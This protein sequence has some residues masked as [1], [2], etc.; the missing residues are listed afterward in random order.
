MLRRL[1]TAPLA[2]V[3]VSVMSLAA[4]QECS[5]ETEPND[6]PPQAT[7]MTGAGPDAAGRMPAGRAHTACF[8]GDLTR[9]DDQ[10]M[11]VW[12]VGELESQQRW[13]IDLE[14]FAGHLTAVRLFSLEFTSDGGGVTS[15]QEIFYTETRDGS[16]TTSA[17]FLVAPGTYYLGVA[18]SAGEGAYVGHLRSVEQLGR[19]A[20]AQRPGQQ[21]R[22]AF[23]VFGPVE[24]E[25][26]Q[27]FA[28][29]E[30]NAGFVWNLELRAAAGTQVTMSLSGPEGELLA[31]KT[32]PDSVARQAGL[33]FTS[34]VYTLKLNGSTGM[35]WL[36]LE[37]LGRRSEGIEVEPNDN[38][39]NATLFPPASEMRGAGDGN[40]YY[41]VQVDAAA[42]AQAW[43]L[44]LQAS[45]NLRIRLY[46]AAG[47]EL[48][49]RT[50]S[51]GVLSALQ[52]SR[53][54]YRLLVSA[55]TGS[56][57]TLALTA[58]AP[59]T[60]G[61][62][63]E[64][65]DT[66][67]S[68]TPLGEES[69]ARG[70]LTQQDRDVFSLTV[71]GEPQLYRVQAVGP[72]VAGLEMLDASGRS[73]GIRARGEGR[74]RLDDL[75]LLPGTH[76]FELRGG[77][78]AY[79]LRAMSLG[80]APPPPSV[81]EMPPP[82][83]PLQPAQASQEEPAAPGGDPLTILPPPAGPPP[84]PG[85]SELEPN[86]DVSRASRLRPGEVHVG[87]LSS[88]T[89]LDF[90]RFHLAAEEYV[91]LELIP[92]TGSDDLALNLIG[93][94]TF[95]S[96]D[97]LDG[98]V[99]VERRLLAGDHS[100]RVSAPSATD[101][102]GYYQVRLTQL[103]TLAAPIDAEPNDDRPDASPLPAELAWDGVVGDSDT[104]DVYRL[105]VFATTTQ[106]R[107]RLATPGLSLAVLS[108]TGYHA[109]TNEGDEMVA[110]LPA[111]ERSWLHIRGRGRYSV[112]VSFDAEPDPAALR[113]SFSA[114]RLAVR[115][116]EQAIPVAAFWYEGQV[117]EAVATV[118]NLGDQPLAVN[119]SAAITN[120]RTSVEAPTV[121]ELAAGESRT[122]PV[123]VDLPSDLRD[124]LAPR[125]ELVATAAGEAAVAHVQLA[126]LCEAP[127]VSAYSYWPMP[128]SLLGRINL[129]SAGFGAT[130]HGESRYPNRDRQLIDGLA[131]PSAG[132]YLAPDSSATF[133]IAGGA[134]VR[135]VGTLLHPL[136]DQQTSRQLKGFVIETSL[137]GSSYSP[138]L[139]A[140]LSSTRVEQAFEFPEPVLARYARLVFVSSQ[141]GG[142][143]AYLGEWKLLAEDLAPF[144]E[145]NLAQPELG[146]HVV[147][148]EPLL[149]DYGNHVIGGAVE[150]RRPLDLRDAPGLSF[151]VGFHHGRAAQV[152]RIEWHDSGSED[153]GS[154][155][156][157]EQVTVEVSLAGPIG[158]W[159]PV[160]EWRLERNAEGVAVLNFDAPTWVRYL[161]LTMPKHSEDRY[162]WPPGRIG[163]IERQ[164]SDG[165]L[166]I[167][168][169]WGHYSREATYE[170]LV[171]HGGIGPTGTSVDAGDTPQTATQLASGAAAQGTVEVAVDADWYRVTLPEG[172]NHVRVRLVGDPTI[173][174]T[175]SLLDE[176]G[177]AVAYEVT[178]EDDGVTLDFFGE[179]GHYLL[180][181]EEPKRTV[182]FAWDTS[183]SVSRF[184]EIIYS[185]IA[186]FALGVD[187]EREAVQ[188]L[189]FNEPSPRWLLP[190]WSTVPERVQRAITDFD[191]NADSSN[192]YLHLLAAGNALRGR[193][194]TKALLFI[195]DAETGGYDL[196]PA[197]WRAL[198]E[199][200]TR[201]FTFEVSSSS[202][203]LP[204]DLM[205]DWAAANSGAYLAAASVGDVD[206]GFARVTCA[207]RR[208]KGYGVEVQTAFVAPPGP[209]SVSVLSV[210]DAHEGAVAVIFDASGS[211]GRAL[212]S[213]EPRIVAARRA[214]V[215]LIADTLPDDAN[216]TLRAFGHVAP[217]SCDTRLDVPLGPL[218]RQAA[219]AAVEGIEP[220]LLS[221]TPLADALAAVA[222]DLAGATGGRTVILITD[223]VESCGGDPAAAVTELR[224]AGPV[225]L[226]IVSLG[227][228]PEAHAEFEALAEAVGASYVDVTSFEGLAASIAA[229]LNP[230]VEFE[231]VDAA[232]AVVAR[233]VVDGEPVEVAMGLYSVR[234]LAAQ[235]VMFEDVRVPGERNVTVRLGTQ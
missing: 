80:P 198:E 207:L 191:R 120:V 59:P 219:L 56:T 83:E 37:K 23:S 114:G 168:G 81:E 167:L 194:G 45:D 216:F 177:A 77:E 17:E 52:L 16:P 4:A 55:P 163:V 100:L 61:F 98:S 73:M 166:S 110:T 108:E 21:L 222:G 32:G 153:L 63:V 5:Y 135:L 82:G 88:P 187:G 210:G 227:L 119:L 115:F 89:D 18:K 24:G 225:D 230:E 44:A 171:S 214:L 127:A 14:S 7:R 169:E 91:R 208:P 197:T 170:L 235:V 184:H 47:V 212:P 131:T 234:V 172:E 25:L 71:T 137:D 233:G 144:G 159:R 6:T 97:A 29:D 87:R 201:V 195:T 178:D 138:V 193:P 126:P 40:D 92:A 217:S 105:P 121:V 226:A 155:G 94:G 134:P 147:R 67:A 202:N 173:A 49:S 203:A 209:G 34:G 157:F 103:G 125:L 192:A 122:V 96:V 104:V 85:W 143:A 146:G 12:E 151:V 27:E 51:S 66:A 102:R 156:R 113:P 130:S 69:Q 185:T 190:L 140:E 53:G 124:D 74:L 176:A 64:P 2:A 215:A 175:Y 101:P 50:G 200:N 112:E 132:G 28:V 15:S 72:G 26:V 221:Q 160:A 189:A 43:D 150:A 79:A 20:S 35:T 90:Y 152:S 148:S 33:G 39:E 10:D 75:F 129:L 31:L 60:Q 205:Q 58:A 183:G 116:S 229:A 9:Q 165:Y 141:G 65:N 224:T 182:I 62:E 186:S 196:L 123:R 199:S 161:R 142:E 3:L 111:G 36:Q 164:A 206:A 22:G 117:V 154:G 128:S 86:D 118:E 38:W 139:T 181:L 19:W 11:F 162:F 42:A 13:V 57:Y 41:R 107:V 218:D 231:V 149:A 93:V 1:V 46:T 220:K 232:G 76:Y 180:G 78:G 211:M 188:L 145:L 179:P 30:D 84:P 68:A 213:G 204:Q 109:T 70:A 48:L 158:P 99:V 133:E 174:Y 223:G 54:D 136:A 106:A 8:A 95:R 228:E